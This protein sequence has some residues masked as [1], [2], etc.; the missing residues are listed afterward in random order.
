MAES[1]ECEGDRAVAQFDVARLA[2]DVVGVGDDE[3]GE[4]AM[5]LF[6]PLG[7]LCVGLT[8]HLCVEV[9]KLLVELFDLCF[10]LEMLEG[11]A[12]G[13]VGEPDGDGAE[14]T[15]VKF[16]MPLHDVEGALGRER[17]VVSVDMIDDLAFLGLGVWGDGETWACRSVSGFGVRCMGRSG[18]DRLRMGRIGKGGGWIHERDG[19]GTKLCLGRDDFDGVA[20]D[21]GGFR[22]G[23]HVVVVWKC[24]RRW[25]L[26]ERM[27]TLRFFCPLLSCLEGV[28]GFFR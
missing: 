18:D 2:H 10:G 13:C 11:A 14:G 17:V 7:A 15:R 1:A 28:N 25:D 6:K 22:G 3:V 9:S 8:R 12:N 4:S 27:E 5:V 24:C 21:G 20:E 26:R 16:W 23:G 19:G